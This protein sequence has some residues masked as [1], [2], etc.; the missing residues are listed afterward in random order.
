MIMA[1]FRQLLR[2]HKGNIPLE[3]FFTE[4]VAYFLGENKDI[5]FSWLNYSHILESSNYV[6]AY[7]ATQKTYK[8]PVRG[9]EKHSDIVIELSNSESYD[10]IFIESKVGSSEG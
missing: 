9:D 2:L 6:E 5:L 4:I 3:D 8:Y 1:L 10:L 7:V